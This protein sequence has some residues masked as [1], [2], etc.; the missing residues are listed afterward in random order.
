MSHVYTTPSGKKVKDLRSLS[1]PCDVK[2][3]FHQVIY[4]DLFTKK[5]AFLGS[6]F[7]GI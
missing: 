5:K 4:Y 7:N 2:F 3:V 6:T 1:Q